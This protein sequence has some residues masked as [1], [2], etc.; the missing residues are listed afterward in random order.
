MKLALPRQHPTKITPQYGVA[1][2]QTRSTFQGQ[3]MTKHL[4]AELMEHF[5]RPNVVTV[6]L[7]AVLM[8]THPQTLKP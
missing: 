5:S 8:A 2:I 6:Y 4:S 3:N 7:C 1:K